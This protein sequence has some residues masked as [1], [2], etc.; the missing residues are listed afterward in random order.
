MLLVCLVLFKFSTLTH[1]VDRMANSAELNRHVGIEAP[2]GP[3]PKP[4]LGEPFG[5]GLDPSARCEIERVLPIKGSKLVEARHYGRSLWGQTAKI[6]AQLPNGSLRDYFL[7][8]A[9]AGSLGVTAKRMIIAE[10]SGL[11]AIRSVSP[12]FVPEAHGW[13]SYHDPTTKSTSYFL[14]ASFHEIGLQPPA[15]HAFV[16]QLAH[17]HKTSAS[18]TG[19]FGFHEPPCH[20]TTPYD[21]I[22]WQS[23]WSALFRDILAY[24]VFLSQRQNEGHGSYEEFERISDLILEKVIPRLL[25]PLEGKIKPCLIHGDLWDENS[26]TDAVTGK[27]FV[28]DPMAFYAH[29]EYEI[30]NWRAAR[31]RLS[32][33]EY[34]DE[35]KRCFPPDEPVEEWDDRNL[36]YSLRYDLSASVLIPGSNLRSVVRDNMW[37]LCNKYFPEDLTAIAA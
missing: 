25:C 16:A 29:N 27:P 26:A 13:G 31:H 21:V 9:S 7:K 33:K 32:R 11:N 22:K 30:G 34:V 12:T 36:L 19:K 15:P 1:N 37:T 28:F 4:H 20:A 10:I 17:L 5:P 8:T 14:L 24:T 3:V 35:Y 6:T 18:P 23:S 2:S